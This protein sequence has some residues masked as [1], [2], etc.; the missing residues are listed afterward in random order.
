MAQLLESEGNPCDNYIIWIA[1]WY[2]QQN[3]FSCHLYSK[4]PL[5]APGS[6]DGSFNCFKE[7]SIQSYVQWNTI[8]LHS[9]RHGAG[10]LTHTPGLQVSN[11]TLQNQFWL[12]QKHFEKFESHCAEKSAANHLVWRLQTS[13]Q[14]LNGMSYWQS[15]H[16]AESLIDER[17]ILYKARGS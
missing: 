3:K 1:F 16:T 9:H 14:V 2:S 15:W 4:K 7:I 11:L 6:R 12:Q 13:C 8:K 17:L 10:W 5:S